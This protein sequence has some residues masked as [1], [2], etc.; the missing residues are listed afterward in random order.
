MRKENKELYQHALSDLETKGMVFELVT[1][2]IGALGHWLP[3]A[4][5]AL[6][7]QI[8]SL[9]KSTATQ[10]LDSAA[11]AI[12]TASQYFVLVS[13][14]LGTK[15]SHSVNVHMPLVQS[16]FLFHIFIAFPILS[17]THSFSLG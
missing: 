3:H 7:Q 6:W 14:Q 8:S 5:S 15:L 10:L 4:H 9:S 13:T 11:K 1:I 12:V 2:E 16:L 17:L